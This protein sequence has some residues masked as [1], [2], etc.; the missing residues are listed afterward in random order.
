MANHIL[1]THGHKFIH[2]H[3]L[4]HLLHRTLKHLN[5][6]GINKHIDNGEGFYHSHENKSIEKR[7]FKVYHLL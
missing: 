1:F 5:K 6:F 3:E 7:V 2:K 4:H